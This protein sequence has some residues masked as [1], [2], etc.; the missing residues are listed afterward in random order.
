MYGNNGR[1]AT[2][3]SQYSTYDTVLESKK[4]PSN[5]IH[6]VTKGNICASPVSTLFFSEHNIS[7]LQ[8]G[9]KNSIL[10]KSQGKYNVVDQNVSELLIVM[11]GFYLKES[12]NSI[13][14]VV[15]QVQKLNTSV[16]TYVV[17][18]I[19]GELEMRQRYTREINTL[20]VPM[21]YGQNTNVTGT[22]QIGMREI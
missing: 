9:I 10:N 2:D 8:K 4:V 19:I 15:G 13:V 18:R 7:M 12:I 5:F 21:S 17:P 6:D 11:R 1:I 22:K 16:L 14:D 3:S 20:P